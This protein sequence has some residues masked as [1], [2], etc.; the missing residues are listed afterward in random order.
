MADDG[1][2]LRAARPV[3]AGAGVA[4]GKGG[5]VGLR[6]RQHIVAVRRVAAAV[7]HLALLGKRGLLGEIVAR[8]VQVGDILG[9]DCAL[10]V[11]P[12]ALADAVLRIHRWLAIGRLRGEIGAPDLRRAE[13]RG[14]R[15]C[16]TM[17]IGASQTTEIAPVAD[18]VAGEEETGPGRLRRCRGCCDDGECEAD[19][20]GEFNERSHGVPPNCSSYA[21]TGSTRRTRYYSALTTQGRPHKT[22][23]PRQN[24]GASY[25]HTSCDQ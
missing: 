12:R 13:P 10:G 9:D 21:A 8:A 25:H 20:R 18:A 11:L 15:Q 14:L 22:K 4:G 24:R 2:A 17:I 7:D 6:S 23:A 19:R 3:L 1:R 5:A 16:L